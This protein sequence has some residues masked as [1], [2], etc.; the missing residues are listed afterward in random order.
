MTRN[1]NI[2]DAKPGD[3]IEAYDTREVSVYAP[4]EYSL[5]QRWIVL[6]NEYD[7][8]RKRGYVDVRIIF[9]QSCLPM[10][11]IFHFDYEKFNRWQRMMEWRFTHEER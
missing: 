3:M 1:F 7:E 10:I 5:A 2:E 8:V 4:G 11:E 6:N 9:T